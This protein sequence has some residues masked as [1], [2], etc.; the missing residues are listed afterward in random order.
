MADSYFNVETRHSL[1]L[2]LQVTFTK[3]LLL[4]VYLL[5]NYHYK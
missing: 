1:L 5:N 2:V 4:L 3:Q